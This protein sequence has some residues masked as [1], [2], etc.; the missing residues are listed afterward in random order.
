MRTFLGAQL[1]RQVSLRSL[2][3]SKASTWPQ[4]GPGFGEAGC[5]SCLPPAAPAACC[6]GLLA[7][8]LEFDEP[9]AAEGGQE[10][11]TSSGWNTCPG[12]LAE[13]LE[14]NGEFCTA[15]RGQT[16]ELYHQTGDTCG[17]TLVPH[18]GNFDRAGGPLSG[19]TGRNEN[20]GSTD[21][22]PLP[23]ICAY[24]KPRKR[25][26]TMRCRPLR[27]D[28]TVRCMPTAPGSL[29]F[30][31]LPLGGS[32]VCAATLCPSH[33]TELNSAERHA[34]PCQEIGRAARCLPA[35][36]GALGFSPFPLGG[37][38]VNDASLCTCCPGTPALCDAAFCKCRAR[39]LF[40]ATGLELFCC[41]CGLHAQDICD[42]GG[43]GWPKGPGISP[44]LA[45]SCRSADPKAV[46]SERQT[47][48][49][50]NPFC[51]PTCGLHARGVCC[52]GGSGLARPRYIPAC[53]DILQKRR[54]QHLVRELSLPDSVGYRMAC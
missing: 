41:T 21:K 5:Q 42:T 7:E 1:A 30:R 9:W 22:R 40:H 12:L 2:G 50:C 34:F 25:R 6:P 3:S 48:V 8:A 31:P 35:L 14:F 43:S 37:L 17:P 15:T 24:T 38:P 47:A 4:T 13:A 18:N 26:R 16:T 32:P 39:Q 45:L 23:K 28:G 51:Y 19:Q 33:H 46:S 10:N 36:Q 52:H 27:A 49:V 20:S 44:R 11:E 54:S 53:R 29:G